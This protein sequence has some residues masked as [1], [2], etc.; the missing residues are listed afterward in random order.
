MLGEYAEQPQGF[1]SEEI[2]LDEARRDIGGQEQVL[3]LKAAAERD[4]GDEHPDMPGH[5][6][7][8]EPGGKFGRTWGGHGVSSPPGFPG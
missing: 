1:G 8:V 5:W 6:Q 4:Q 7:P 2:G 3:E